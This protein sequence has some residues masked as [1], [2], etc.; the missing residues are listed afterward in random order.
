M[1]SG[2]TVYKVLKGLSLTFS[3]FC[4]CPGSNWVT[5]SPCSFFRLWSPSPEAF[6]LSVF[7][8]NWHKGMGQ[9]MYSKSFKSNKNS[10]F[11]PTFWGGRGISIRRLCCQHASTGCM[12][13]HVMQRSQLCIGVKRKIYAEYPHFHMNERQQECM[14]HSKRFPLKEGAESLYTQ[15]SA[16]CMEE[17]KTNWCVFFFALIRKRGCMKLKEFRKEKKS[18]WE[19]GSSALSQRRKKTFSHSKDFDMNIISFNVRLTW[20][21]SHQHIQEIS[22]FLSKFGFLL[23]TKTN[24]CHSS[25]SLSLFLIILLSCPPLY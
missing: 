2:A 1:S 11:K 22:F 10:G 9:K 19:S 21:H 16:V 15:Q 20:H 13:W 4:Q 3:F 18:L 6:F 8:K 17:K 14:A 25:P 23:A 24:P 5:Q 12:C 7:F